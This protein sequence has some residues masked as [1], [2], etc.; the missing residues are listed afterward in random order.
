M[1]KGR[2]WDFL[3]IFLIVSLRNK[4]FS[5]TLEVVKA[6]VVQSAPE[7]GEILLFHKF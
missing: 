6:F 7:Q 4:H 1:Y 5:E 3:N 2:H